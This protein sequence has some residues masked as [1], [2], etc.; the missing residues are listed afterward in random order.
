MGTP[1]TATPS[2]GG[3]GLPHSSLTLLWPCVRAWSAMPARD[4]R[5]RVS[6]DY[7]SSGMAMSCVAT[8]RAMRALDGEVV[9]GS[10]GQ[11]FGF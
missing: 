9:G 4:R 6:L 5:N 3:S 2:E 1:S 8:L 11:M 10:V 7:A